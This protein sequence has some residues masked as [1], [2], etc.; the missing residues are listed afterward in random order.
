M[1]ARANPGNV[2]AT[3]TNSVNW[4]NQKFQLIIGQLSVE[5]NKPMSGHS[6]T[7]VDVP[8]LDFLSADD[9][10]NKSSSQSMTKRLQS[11]KE[12]VNRGS[13]EEHLEDTVA[14]LSK[15]PE[16]ENYLFKA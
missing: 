12:T 11:E 15:L 4:P 16:A 2:D 3:L 10:A 1:Q 13:D 6:S 5:I 7:E 14:M 8:M 9:A